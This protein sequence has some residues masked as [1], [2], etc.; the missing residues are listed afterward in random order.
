MGISDGTV[1]QTERVCDALERALDVQGHAG[2]GTRPQRGS[3]ALV[4]VEWSEF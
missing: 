1:V 4:M 3:L 2:D